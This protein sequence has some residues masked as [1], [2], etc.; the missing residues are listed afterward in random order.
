M[1]GD[2]DK[3]FIHMNHTLRLL[4][5]AQMKGTDFAREWNSK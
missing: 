3:R 1:Q 4:F 5:L 2:A